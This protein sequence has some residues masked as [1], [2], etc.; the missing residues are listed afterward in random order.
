MMGNFVV[1]IELAEPLVSK[2]QFELVAQTAVGSDDIAVPDD[3]HPQHTFRINGRRC[4]CKTLLVFRSLL[5]CYGDP[6]TVVL[7]WCSIDFVVAGR[8]PRWLNQPQDRFAR[9]TMRITL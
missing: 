4:R 7:K 6:E 1:E 5:T 3:E 2:V 9:A 8:E